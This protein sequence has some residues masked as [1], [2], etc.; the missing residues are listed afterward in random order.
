MLWGRN[1]AAAVEMPC[2]LQTPLDEQMGLGRGHQI[3]SKKS[4]MVT[5]TQKQGSTKLGEPLI[6]KW[7]ARKKNGQLLCLS[8]PLSSPPATGVLQQ[9]GTHPS[10]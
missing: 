8:H 1:A 7:A 10:P 6:P 4:H 9:S 3:Q 2:L 5:E